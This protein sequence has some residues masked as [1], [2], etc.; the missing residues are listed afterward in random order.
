MEGRYAEKVEHTHLIMI[1]EGLAAGRE[2]SRA[3]KLASQ[4]AT[5]EVTAEP[6]PG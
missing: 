5:I 4:P 6:E 3:R 1:A 2:K